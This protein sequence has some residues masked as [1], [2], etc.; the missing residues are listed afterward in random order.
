M[1]GE[2]PKAAREIAAAMGDRHDYAGKPRQRD[3]E[4]RDQCERAFL[5]DQCADADYRLLNSGLRFS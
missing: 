5:H 4:L 2:A 1:T 3:A